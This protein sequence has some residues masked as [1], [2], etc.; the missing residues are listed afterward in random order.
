MWVNTYFGSPSFGISWLEEL[1]G[2]F[3]SFALLAQDNSMC[4]CGLGKAVYCLHV[5]IF[6]NDLKKH[7]TPSA[8][9][10]CFLRCYWLLS[11]WTS[12]LD[13][14][15]RDKAYILLLCGLC[16]WLTNMKLICQ[17]LIIKV[18]LIIIHVQRDK[19]K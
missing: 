12:T 8:L 3:E 5:P 2:G 1:G 7:E 18:Y 4:R 17:L 15:T 16:I 9:I 11:M 19:N 10:N 13:F 14:S 6:N